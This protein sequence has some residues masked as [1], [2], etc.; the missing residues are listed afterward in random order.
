MPTSHPPSW[1]AP[2]VQ[3]YGDIRL[4][5]NV[6]LWPN[7]VMRAEIYHIEIGQYTN[8][9]D[10][11]MVHIGNGPSIV[12]AYCSLTH[13]CTIHGA[14]IGD[15]CLIGINATI[16]DG[17]TI[18]DNC[19]VAGNCIVR[20]GTQIPANS[21]VAGVPGKVVA[22][23]NNYVANRMN[24]WA[25]HENALAYKVGNFRRWSDPDYVEKAIAYQ[26]STEAEFLTLTNTRSNS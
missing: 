22:E 2:S 23:H 10:F 16:M 25:Y 26:Q 21:V 24:A 19:I 18:G 13:H 11:V 9:Q 12:G 15:N 8:V 1:Q 17:A 3:L 5:Q 20:E 6:N 7:V 14:T 4:G